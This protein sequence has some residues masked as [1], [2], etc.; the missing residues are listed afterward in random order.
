MLQPLRLVDFFRAGVQRCS[1][2]ADLFARVTPPRYNERGQTVYVTV[3]AVG[4]SFRFLPTR[5]VRESIAFLL[6]WLATEHGLLVHEYEFLSNHFHFSAKDPEG[7]ISEFL[8]QFDSML[9]RQLNALRGTTGVNFE[10]EPG[11]VRIVDGEGLVQ[12]SVYTL[13]NAV[14]AHLVERV[15]HWKGPSSYH[16]EYGEAVTVERPKCGLWAETRSGR[17]SGK[18][19][20]RWRRRYR[21]RS[22]APQTAT[23][24][25]ARPDARPDLTSSQLRAE[26]RRR[27]A[28][29]EEELIEER[30]RT[31]K[32]V[33]GWLGVL[34][35]HYLAV[36]TSSRVLFERRPRLTGHDKEA[37]ARFAKVLTRFTAAYRHALT[38]FKAGAR[39]TTFPY[40]TL[41]MARRYNLRCATA[42]P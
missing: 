40:G 33:L 36:P 1:A 8:Q 26:I 9:S 21:G 27:V 23:F 14:S 25:L 6:A 30:R 17:R 42:P 22:R 16:L 13:T 39:T 20:S 24:T 32:K 11:I 31:G 29:R 18:H 35:Q 19:P 7:R 2:A 41:Q 28:A 38:R 37:C 10:R 5:E 4:R 3:Q 34:R 15:R 12:K